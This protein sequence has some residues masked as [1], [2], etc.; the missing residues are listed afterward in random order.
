MWRNESHTRSGVTHTMTMTL[1]ITR[2]YVHSIT[3]NS[4][5][6]SVWARLRWHTCAAS[7]HSVVWITLAVSPAKD[8]VQNCCSDVQVPVWP[9]SV[10]PG[11]ILCADISSR[12]VPP[13][14][15]H[16]QSANSASCPSRDNQS[17]LITLEKSTGRHRK[18]IVQIIGMVFT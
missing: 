8:Y 10:I 17:Y 14:I 15:C 5:I 11:S 6:Q 2:R 9:G 1:G 18:C 7:S 12:P 3:Y 4:C 13:K 16:N